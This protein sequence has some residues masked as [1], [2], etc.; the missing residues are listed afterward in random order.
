MCHADRTI[1]LCNPGN[2]DSRDLP[3]AKTRKVCSKYASK[4]NDRGASR[5]GFV[6]KRLTPTKRERL[7]LVDRQLTGLLIL[8]SARGSSYLYPRFKTRSRP[9]QPPPDGGMG[10]CVRLACPARHLTLSWAILAPGRR[11][12]GRQ[13]I[14]G[15]AHSPDMTPDRRRLAWP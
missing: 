1:E 7:R 4:M 3:S 10:G 13:R 6:P 14:E 8:T 2:T 15:S 9:K 5:G 12:V 11:R